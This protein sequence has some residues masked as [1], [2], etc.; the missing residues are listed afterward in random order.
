M[1][2]R[3]LEEAGKM[4]IVALDK[5]GTITQGE[6]EVTDIITAKGIISQ[7]LLQLAFSLEKKSEHPLAGAIIRYAK[8]QNIEEF[9]VTDF[10]ALPGN[11]LSAVIEGEMLAGGNALFI[12][13]QA[14]VPEELK[15]QAEKLAGEG[16]TPLYFAK[17]KRLI[18]II[19]V[20]DIIKEDSPKAVQELKDMGIHVVMLT[21]D[22]ERTANA[23]GKLA[24]VDEVIAGDRK[25]VV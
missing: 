25:S 1:L 19:A 14:E 3:S 20:A 2:F 23:V 10:T 9:E 24:G 8:N 17:G 18:G 4:Q 13:K 12:S 5:T 21:G 15:K 6:P 7:E 22:N 16:K 11:G